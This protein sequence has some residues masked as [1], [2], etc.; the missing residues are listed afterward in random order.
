MI[1]YKLECLIQK[2]MDQLLNFELA[3]PIS[4]LGKKEQKK[5][6]HQ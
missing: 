5:T 4:N 1:I 6:E 3:S 2:N